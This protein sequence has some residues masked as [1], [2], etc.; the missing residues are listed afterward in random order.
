M[1]IYA[2]PLDLDAD[3]NTSRFRLIAS[4]TRQ[5]LDG[6]VISEM[7]ATGTILAAGIAYFGNIMDPPTYRILLID[8]T[9]GARLFIDPQ[10]PEV[11]PLSVR[12]SHVHS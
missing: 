8:I 11:G 9:S 12:S 2:I 7:H 4:V 10:T 1:G 5:Y 3:L 6:G